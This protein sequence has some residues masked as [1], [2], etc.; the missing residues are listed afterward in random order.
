MFFLLEQY[1]I[2]LNHAR[3]CERSEA[4]QWRAGWI[5]S[6]RSRET[7]GCGLT[8]RFRPFRPF[9]PPRRSGRICVASQAGSAALGDE[10]FFH[11][12]Q[13]ILAKEHC[14]A[15]EEGWDAKAAPVDQFLRCGH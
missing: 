6:L 7:K 12:T 15:D 9:R 4:I 1:D 2:A 14:V 8:A 3:H 13:A 5:A 10:F 11:F